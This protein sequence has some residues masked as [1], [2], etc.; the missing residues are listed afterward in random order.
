M[1]EHDPARGSA[2]HPKDRAE[3]L[4]EKPVEGSV[5]AE[6]HEE[7]GDGDRDRSAAADRADAAQ[8]VAE[9]ANRRPGG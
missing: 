3:G 2:N 5:E 8:E 7:S 1:E 6:G 9:I 4:I